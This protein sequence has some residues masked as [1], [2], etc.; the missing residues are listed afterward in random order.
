TQENL[1]RELPTAQTKALDEL[2]RAYEEY[3]L[4]LTELDVVER[5]LVQTTETFK[6]YIDEH[7]LWIPSGR[8]FS[9]GVILDAR[10]GA[11][12]FFSWARLKEVLDAV[13][14]DLVTNPGLNVIAIL[15]LGGLFGFRRK[16]RS[17]VVEIGKAAAKPSCVS[18]WPTFE[19]L[20]FTL[21]LALSVP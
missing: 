13:M 10:A 2:I 19:S 18:L 9:P 1:L 8:L 17:K 21:L 11:K 14:Y 4:K 3:S 20:F 15:L 16:F 6:T 5:S 12:W 7:I